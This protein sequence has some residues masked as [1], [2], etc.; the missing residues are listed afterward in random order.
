MDLLGVGMFPPP[1]FNK[2]EVSTTMDSEY[3]KYDNNE[4]CDLDLNGILLGMLMGFDQE[5]C[6]KTMVQYASLSTSSVRTQV[7]YAQEINS[8]ILCYIL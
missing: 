5:Q 6:N 2:K 7:H 8:G 1:I 4:T 3:N